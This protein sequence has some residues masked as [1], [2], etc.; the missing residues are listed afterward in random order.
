M[1]VKTWAK[2]ATPNPEQ[3]TGSLRRGLLWTYGVVQACFV[4]Y[5]IYLHILA[6]TAKT[7][8][9]FHDMGVEIGRSLVMNEVASWWIVTSLVLGVLFLMIYFGRPKSWR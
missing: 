7:G 6:E 1:N 4:G 2:P 5:V 3:R 8:E 9:P